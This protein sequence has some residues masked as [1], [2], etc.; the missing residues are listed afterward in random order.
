MISDD[1]TIESELNKYDVE[2]SEDSFFDNLKGQKTISLF[3]EIP[4]TYGVEM[5]KALFPQTLKVARLFKIKDSSN[6]PFNSL[7]LLRKL[8]N[9]AFIPLVTTSTEVMEDAKLLF[10]KKLYNRMMMNYI[11]PRIFRYKNPFMPGSKM[12]IQRNN[13]NQYIEEV[14]TYL[15]KLNSIPSFIIKNK[16]NSIIDLSGILSHTMPNRAILMRPNVHIMADK[17]S[18]QIISRLGFKNTPDEQPLLSTLKTT[19]PPI[20]N[21]FSSITHVTQER[22]YLPG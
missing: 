9:V 21:L 1:I 20:G 18:L 11:F 10:G 7:L 6:E 19:I 3:E 5:Y 16:K 13:P 15:P 2:F 8:S 12:I 22:H 4:A 17:L 14:K